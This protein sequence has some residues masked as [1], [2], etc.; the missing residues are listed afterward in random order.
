MLHTMRRRALGLLLAMFVSPGMCAQTPDD[1]YLTGYV[2][3]VLERDL[4]IQ[5][6][7]LHVSGG[8]VTLSDVNLN[9]ADIPRVTEVLRRIPGITEVEILPVLHTTDGVGG[10]PSTGPG[11][12][13]QTRI[14]A[15]S[16]S[17]LLRAPLLFESLHADPR[18]PHF[19]AAYHRYG[20]N[21]ELES[22]GT[23]S[24]GESF[25]I[26]R[27]SVGKHAQWELGLQA[28]V[29]AI[30]ALDAPSKDL[31][32]AD[33]FVGP[34]LG[35]RSRNLS[36]LT[37]LYHQ[38]SH[39][40]DEYLLRTRIDRINLSYEVADLLLSYD[41]SDELRIYGG[42]GYI[43]HSI[44]KLKPWT[45]QGGVEWMGRPFSGGSIRP[46][47]AID[48]QAREEQGWNEDISLRAGLQFED[49]AERSMRFQ[50]LIEYYHGRSPNGQFLDQDIE[51]V[52]LGLHFHL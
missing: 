31:V 47:V 40:G 45:A 5:E 48:L 38:S 42:G 21:D 3:A 8:K 50:I 6:A 36:A 44:P 20:G 18:W 2:K 39:L 22:V 4:R 24:F 33:Y 12:T 26:H 35:W 51:F 25:S 27:R 11:T 17:F 32:N 29:F 14:E 37:R 15:P 10:L 1:A 46:M 41:I 7:T 30:F 19:S 28:G 16:S 43:L 23:V 13:I 9:N 52:G 34:V 49:A